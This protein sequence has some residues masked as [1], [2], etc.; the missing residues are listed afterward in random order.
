MNSSHLVGGEKQVVR[1]FVVLDSMEVECLGTV[2][3]LF[4]GFPYC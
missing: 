4:T 3:Y 1:P 2:Y